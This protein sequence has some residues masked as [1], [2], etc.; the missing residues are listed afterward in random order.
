[1]KRSS[2]KSSII[3][4]VAVI[5]I[6]FLNKHVI[7]DRYVFYPKS[8]ISLASY[9]FTKA[10]FFSD[11]IG[12][13]ENFNSLAKENNRLKQNQETVLNLKA[14]IDILENENNFLRRAARISEEFDHSIVDAGIFNLN[15]VPTGYNVLLN[16]G[17]RDDISEGDVV[18][19]A[20]GILVGTIQKVM[21]N[22]SRVFF[23]SDPEFK[24]TAKVVG[25]NTAGIARGALND[26]L[27][28]D[29]IVQSDEIKE[30]DKIISTGNDLFPPALI[31]GSVDYVEANDS[32]MFKKVH[33]RPG[34]KDTQLGRVLVIKIK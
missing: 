34:I 1:M 11:F 23:I 14:Q 10:E 22:F 13:I 16:K 8:F 27:Y 30:E 3:L 12:K 19:T 4:V 28:L 25:S 7:K 32:Q 33:I 17:A 29:F 2:V 21:P 26:G 6:V 24:I 5:G 31:I 20:E 18:V 15:L 9:L